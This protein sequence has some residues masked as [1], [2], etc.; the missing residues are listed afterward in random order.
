MA[1]GPRTRRWAT[2][3]ILWVAVT[4]GA[5]LI[6]LQPNEALHQAEDFP[7]R[8]RAIRFEEWLALILIALHLLF[9]N[10]AW[11]NYLHE[12]NAARHEDSK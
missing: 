8:L 1:V 3:A 5:L 7:A 10:L 11:L 4:P 12:R 6:L 2:L 9:I